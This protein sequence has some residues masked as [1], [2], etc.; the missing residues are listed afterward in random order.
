MS[1]PDDPKAT[2]AKPASRRFFH[3]RVAV[4]LTILACVLLW[5]WRDVRRRNARNAWDHTLDVAVV[6]VR[7]ERVD[8]A[9]VAALQT[10][11]PALEDRLTAEMSRHHPGAPHPFRF[12][13]V[14]PVDG[15]A[16]PPAPE[17]DGPVDLAKYSFA[18]SAYV[19]DID[20]RAGVDADLY[21]VRI[22]VA[23][24]RPRRA[25]RTIAE[26]RSEQGGRIGIVEVEIDSDAEGAHLPLVVVAH[27]L[28]HTLGAT[29]K[30][31]A[32]GR[33]L[34]PLGLAEPDR[35]PVYPQR[36]AEI[37]SRNRPVSATEEKVPE[38][39]DQIAVGPA[40]AREIGWLR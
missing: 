40:T 20:A 16:P 8:D 9:A 5:A 34:V 22:Y 14:P 1:A 2:A 37:M 25:E 18:Q 31:D 6:L 11:V 12:R 3:I 7:L 23:L 32:S 15:A 33:S 26:G 17:G 28:M 21:D 38:G 35:M 30:Y 4:L 29:D 36:Y 27:E 10:G 24:R 13:I 19:K 39:F